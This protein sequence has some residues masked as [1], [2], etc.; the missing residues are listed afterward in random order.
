MEKETKAPSAE[1]VKKAVDDER[2]WLE[3]YNAVSEVSGGPVEDLKGVPLPSDLHQ[4]TP[5]VC[6]KP[7]KE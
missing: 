4:E 3:K 7:F 2:H 6:K 5:P 1:D